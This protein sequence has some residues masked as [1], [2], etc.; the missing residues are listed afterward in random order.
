MPIYTMALYALQLPWCVNLYLCINVSFASIFY[1]CVD[2]YKIIKFTRFIQFF[3]EKSF[4]NIF[5]EKKLSDERI[6]SY[7]AKAELRSV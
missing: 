5:S 2:S 7:L 6:N 1:I 4:E 3:G